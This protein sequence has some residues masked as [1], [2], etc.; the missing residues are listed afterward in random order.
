MERL[1]EDVKKIADLLENSSYTVV[2]TGAG[3]ST[4]GSG[5][6]FHSPDSGLLKMVAPSDFTIHRFENSPEAFYEAGA[7]YFDLMEKAD[8]NEVHTSLAELEKRGLV[9]TVVT[10]NIDGLHQKAGSKNVLEIHG[11][12]RSASCMECDYQAMLED[13]L[14]ETKESPQ[15]PR[16]PKCGEV[17]KPDVVFSN[18]PPPPDFHRA[19][20]ELEKADLVIIVG[21]NMQT[22]PADRLPIGSANLVV[23]NHAPTG[24]DSQAGV[25]V[26]ASTARVMRLLLEELDRRK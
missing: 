1:H 24:Y 6:G 20:E 3:I 16:C 7:P 13:V 18:E 14:P 2:I 22:P 11:T 12:L 15:P 8:P 10:Q 26:N 4:E 5:P 19:K 17:L 21:S 23:V 25:V 9:K